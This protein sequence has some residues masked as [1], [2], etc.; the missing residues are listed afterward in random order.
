MNRNMQPD[1]ASAA[2]ELVK[3]ITGADPEG[4]FLIF[5]GRLDVIA[6][7]ARGVARVMRKPS[8]PSS[9]RIQRIQASWSRE[10][11]RARIV[12]TDVVHGRNLKTGKRFGA[13]IKPIEV[14]IGP[15]PKRT[16]AIFEQSMDI[17]SAKAMR[18]FPILREDSEGEPV[19]SVQAIRGSEPYES[20]IILCEGFYVGYRW[21]FDAVKAGKPNII[22]VNDGEAG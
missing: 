11:K 8:N 4:A 5:S 14:L 1:F 19:E 12:L 22:P 7:E 21:P 6:L 18:V 9:R 3:A 10:P 15:G 20:L 13:A 16:V 17:R 2:V